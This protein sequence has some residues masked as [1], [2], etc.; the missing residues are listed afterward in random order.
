M[1]LLVLQ[2]QASRRSAVSDAVK[3]LPLRTR[4]RNT[5]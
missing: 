1:R 4:A 5:L 2:R 3:H